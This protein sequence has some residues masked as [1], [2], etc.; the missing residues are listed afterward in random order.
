MSP[1]TLSVLSSACT[2]YVE[3]LK[4]STTCLHEPDPLVLSSVK[5]QMIIHLFIICLHLFM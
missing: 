4:F 5:V 3:V 2:F 1:V